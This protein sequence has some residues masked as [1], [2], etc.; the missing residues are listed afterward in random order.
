MD[1]DQSMLWLSMTFLVVLEPSSRFDERLERSFHTAR[2]RVSSVDRDI[3]RGAHTSTAKP[4][5]DDSWPNCTRAAN[6]HGPNPHPSRQDQPSTHDS[7]P[8]STAFGD[9]R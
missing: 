3:D 2:G 8:R 7:R 9:K 4:E 1:D 6:R 5:R